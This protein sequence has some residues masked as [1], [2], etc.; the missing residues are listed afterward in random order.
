M[1]RAQKIYP[2][3]LA[4]GS[5]TRFWPLSRKRRPKQLLPLAGDRP[6]LLETL[7]R[8]RGL[9][10]PADILVVAGKS[11]ATAIRR[12]LP[13]LPRANLLLEPAARNTAP[14]IGWAATRLLARDGDA[15]LAVLPSDHHIQNVA[16][17]R[18][19]LG[20][21]AALARE[22]ALVTLGITPRGPETGF[23]YLRMAKAAGHRPGGAREVEAFPVEAFVE[24][25]SR[26]TAESYLRSGRYLWNAGI[27]V[28]RASVVLAEI[29]RQLP[30]LARALD[31]IAKVAGTAAEADAVRRWFPKVPA[32]SIDYGVMEKAAAPVVVV[33]ADIGWSDLGSFD[34]LS[35][36]RRTD[37]AGNL[38]EGKVILVDCRECVVLARERP[39]AVVGGERLVVVD[40]GDAI[41]VVPRDRVQEVRQVVAEL[42]RRGLKEVL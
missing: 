33:P 6:L 15:V 30:A 20:T 7:D 34:A 5:G 31:A 42:E 41:L 36:V 35:Q 18:K 32:I 23:G 28:F 1:P 19:L 12:M 17:F 21:A 9:V 16:K 8:V 25:P 3:I 38:V 11:H 24:K 2:V 10:A 4:G 22:G 37:R 39:V 29:H 13:R 27:F 14:A 40:A 26:E